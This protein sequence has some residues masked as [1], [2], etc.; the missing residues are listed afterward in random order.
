MTIQHYRNLKSGA[1][2]I[3]GSSRHFVEPRRMTAAAGH[4]GREMADI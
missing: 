1:N 4:P 2:C 3:G